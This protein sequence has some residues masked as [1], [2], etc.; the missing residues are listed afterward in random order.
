MAPG[1]S[2]RG[3]GFDRGALLLCMYWPRQAKI[4]GFCNFCCVRF[5]LRDSV[6]TMVCFTW[7]SGRVAAQ[8][9]WDAKWWKRQ[10]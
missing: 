1:N 5:N 6:G 9:A 4:V 10:R 3:G 7:C 8:M 2:D